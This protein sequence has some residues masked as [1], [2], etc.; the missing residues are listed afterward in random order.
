M[1][2]PGQPRGILAFLKGSLLIIREI[3]YDIVCDMLLPGIDHCLSPQRRELTGLRIHE[4]YEH[5]IALLAD[6][7]DEGVQAN[8]G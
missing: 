3:R 1:D 8:I 5:L 6:R 4:G 7:Q 2:T